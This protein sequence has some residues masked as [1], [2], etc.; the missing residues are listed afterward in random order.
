MT[1]IGREWAPDMNCTGWLDGWPTWL[2][3]SGDEW[4][5]CCQIHDL[6]D[7]TFTAALALGKCVAA[8]GYPTMGAIMTLGLLVFGRGY[9]FLRKWLG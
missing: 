3:G 5:G 4:I 8:S 6:S 9:L 7:Q 2:G 1:N